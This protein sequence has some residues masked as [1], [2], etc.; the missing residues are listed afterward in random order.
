MRLLWHP[1]AVTD[2]A[3]IVD[4]IAHENPSAAYQIH[5]EILRQA[6]V[7]AIYLEMG[8]IGRVRGAR[9][10]VIVG[11]PYLAAYRFGGGAVIVLRLLHGARPWPRE[12]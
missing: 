3:E 2:L 8:R 4:Y 5:G 12:L 9:E 7:L 11:T 1:L 6:D 10:L